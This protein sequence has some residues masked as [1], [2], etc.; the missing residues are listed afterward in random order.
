VINVK[1]ET[2]ACRIL[3][4]KSNTKRSLE[5]LRHTWKNNVEMDLKETGR[6]NVDW[7]HLGQVRDMWRDTVN[8]A[9]NFRFPKFRGV[10]RVSAKLLASQQEI[11][12]MELLLPSVNR[13]SLISNLAR[14]SCFCLETG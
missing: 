9:M 3:V 5:R 6:N 12:S 13:R 11:F 10:S 8:T 14:Y 2:N 1:E 7:I 4:G